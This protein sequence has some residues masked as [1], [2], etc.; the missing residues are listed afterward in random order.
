[1]KFETVLDFYIYYLEIL[2]KREKNHTKV[3]PFS[4]IANK[5]EVFNNSIEIVQGT[6]SNML[7]SRSEFNYNVVHMLYS[8]SG[9]TDS[10]ILKKYKSSYWRYSN[11]GFY[12]NTIGERLYTL[13]G[14]QI[15]R[16]VNF[17]KENIYTSDAVCFMK[18]FE[19]ENI[20]CTL[21][22]HFYYRD[23]R[24]NLELSYK[25]SSLL[26]Y[27]N[28]D[29]FIYSSFLS[30]MSHWLD[31][32]HGSLFLKCHSIFISENDL[33]RA[34]KLLEI[35]KSLRNIGISMNHRFSS[36]IETYRSEFSEAINR[37]IAWDTVD[38]TQR[39]SE[40]LEYIKKYFTPYIQD[41]LLI[42]LA[43]RFHQTDSDYKIVLSQL[44]DRSIG[45]F[46]ETIDKIQFNK[47]LEVI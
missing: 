21:N 18:S 6:H 25:G 4:E 11:E 8:L 26:E 27:T 20:E 32:E 31:V 34:K 30:L 29:L 38:I 36:S 35:G 40:E 15:K 16:C 28:S 45:K 7:F 42:L 3:V 33:E 22:L 41:L 9:R 10:Y 24:L 37:I 39:V 19:N 12:V 13:Y 23:N 43:D 1:M 5:V 14:N 17:L 47:L 2:L 46:K 44:S